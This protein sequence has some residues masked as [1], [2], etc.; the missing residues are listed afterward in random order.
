MN[1]L[2]GLLIV[3]SCT[4]LAIADNW[5]AWRGPAGDGHC[6]EKGL[7]TTWNTTKN[8]R[9]KVKLP[10]EGN[11]TPVVWGDRIFV[12]Q[13][14]DWTLKPPQAGGPAVAAKRSLMCFR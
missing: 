8:V 1:Y 9:W 3:L 12:T 6:S 4:G 11:S 2:R 14:S 7:P 5:P 10:A 13:A